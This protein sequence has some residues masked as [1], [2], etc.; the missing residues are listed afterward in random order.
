MRET[1]RINALIAL[2][3]F[4]GCSMQPAGVLPVVSAED[5]AVIDAAT[6]RA[7][8]EFATRAA[9]R[10]AVAVAEARDRAEASFTKVTAAR[11][12]AMKPQAPEP[13]D[14]LAGCIRDVVAAE[15][16]ARK[17]KRPLLIWVGT[18]CDGWHDKLPECVHARVPTYEMDST[19][20]VL[21]PTPT[22]K[23]LYWLKSDLDNGNVEPRDIRNVISGRLGAETMAAPP[24]AFAPVSMWGAA[25]CST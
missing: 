4:A 15:I 17:L 18:G 2:L 21:V 3:F 10:D 19:P 22:G 23:R 25:N 13:E 7:G 5:A 8:A 24:P 9:Q 11:E 16:L 6:A 12:L 1:M 14:I 20:R